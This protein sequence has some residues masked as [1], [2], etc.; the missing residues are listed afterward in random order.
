L[1]TAGPIVQASSLPPIPSQTAPLVAIKTADPAFTTLIQTEAA[2][3]PQVSVIAQPS[4][5]SS[6]RDPPEA[7]QTQAPSTNTFDISQKSSHDDTIGGSTFLEVLPAP[8][9]TEQ[10]FIIGTQTVEAGS[11]ITKSGTVYSLASSG[12]AVF[13]DGVQTKPLVGSLITTVATPFTE[14][15]FVIGFQSISQGFDATVS[16]TV[17]SLPPTGGSVYINGVQTKPSVG[18]LK[19]IMQPQSKE[20][21]VIGTQTISQGFRATVSGTI[22]SLAATGDS[23]YVDGVQTKPSV[24]SLIT[25]TQSPNQVI[26]VIGTQSIS[27]GSAVTVFGTVYSLATDGSVF[28]NGVPTTPST[29]SF[30]YLSTA[31][32][33]SALTTQVGGTAIFPPSSVTSQTGTFSITGSIMPTDLGHTKGTPNSGSGFR[34]KEQTVLGIAMGVATLAL[35]CL[36]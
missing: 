28:V 27:E 13:V 11:A 31:S 9:S 25:I 18:S 24:G 29:R 8:S 22:Y 30:P 5:Q 6:V 17:Y 21:F 7:S 16:G 3:R 20:V 23:I 34:T 12:H 4:S 15:V 1:T 19:T 35:L 26:F 14:E 2:P 36:R 10:I 32:P 33:S